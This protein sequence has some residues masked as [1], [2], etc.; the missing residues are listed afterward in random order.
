MLV[1]RADGMGGLAFVGLSLPQDWAEGFRGDVITLAETIRLLPPSADETS[2]MLGETDVGDD[3]TEMIMLEGNAIESPGEPPP[4]FLWQ[5]QRPLGEEPGDFGGLLDTVYYPPGF[6]V[7]SDDQFGLWIVDANDGAVLGNLSLGEGTD[8]AWPASIA[9]SPDLSTLFIS[10]TFSGSILMMDTETGEVVDAFGFGLFELFSPQALAVASD[11]LYATNFM[12]DAGLY[13][14]LKFTLDGTFLWRQDLTALAGVDGHFTIAVAPDDT[15]YVVPFTDG[16]FIHID[17]DGSFIG[18]TPSAFSFVSS[19]EIS[20]EGTFYVGSGLG[21]SMSNAAGEELATYGIPFDA[22]PFP[23]G[24]YLL[25][26]GITTGPSGAIYYVDYDLDN[27]HSI[28][29]AFTFP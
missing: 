25:P 28:I 21:V 29:G 17:S 6:L 18:T 11:A 8:A 14:L 24:G 2:Q 20:P 16:E 3:L 10:D 27:N 5:V 1:Q 12:D 4:G 9:L 13:E 26:A 15:V 19:L 22:G 7:V 23:N